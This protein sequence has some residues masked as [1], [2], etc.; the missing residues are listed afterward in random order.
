MDQVANHVD[1]DEHGIV[2]SAVRSYALWLS[3]KWSREVTY[4]EAHA[5]VRKFASENPDPGNVEGVREDRQDAGQ[6]AEAVCD[7]GDVSTYTHDE[8]LF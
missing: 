7:G 2:V 5:R 6:H 8:R 4:E 1:V 3:K